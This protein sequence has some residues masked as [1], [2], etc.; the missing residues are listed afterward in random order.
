M[1]SLRLLLAPWILEL[2]ERAYEAK[3]RAQAN[4][5]TTAVVII[6]VI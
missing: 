6:V 4:F 3:A 1:P 2:A 5:P